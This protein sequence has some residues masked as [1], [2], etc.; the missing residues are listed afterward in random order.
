M[1]QNLRS[2]VREHLVRHELT[3]DRTNVAQILSAMG[4]VLGTDDVHSLTAQLQTDFDG[5]GP[6]QN[7]IDDSRVTDVLVNGPQEIYCDNGFSLQRCDAS[8]DDEKS[9]RE[10]A[11]RLAALAGRRLDDA[12]PWV[13]GYLPQ[14]IRLHAVLPPVA[15]SHTRISLRIP[16]TL[17]MSLAEIATKE[18]AAILT[19]LIQTESMCIAGPTGAGKTT[20]LSA[21]LREV[22]G[23]ERIVVLEDSPELSVQHPHTVYLSARP[24]N[25]EGAG[26]VSLRDIVRQS[27][28]MRP[29]RIVVGEVR[30]NEI[31]DLLLALGSGHRGATTVHALSAQHTITR[32][33]TLLLVAGMN[34]RA[35][36]AQI[37]AAL[38]VVVTV[39]REGNRRFIGEIFK[40]IHSAKGLELAPL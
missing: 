11:Q 39:R 6:L 38:G 5:L 15:G 27:L 12:N 3:V 26:M 25:A 4:Q 31:V 13:D 7:L 22:P 32:L 14:G 20:V 16:R 40:V 17:T 35:I 2:R 24:A 34:E 37:A 36:D 9:L 10:F 28:R 29:D 30:G 1:N 23:D 18:Q 19:D 33:R 8:F 21:L